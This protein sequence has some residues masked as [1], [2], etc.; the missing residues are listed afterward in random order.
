MVRKLGPTALA[1]QRMAHSPDR[2]QVGQ[3]TT[4]PQGGAV[5]D[6]NLYEDLQRGVADIVDHG[7]ARTNRSE[8]AISDRRARVGSYPAA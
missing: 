6:D 7:A 3:E 8:P 2:G 5:G 1:R 4:P